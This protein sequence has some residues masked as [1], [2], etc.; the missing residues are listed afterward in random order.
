LGYSII[1]N[2]FFRLILVFCIIP[3]NNFLLSQSDKKDK[4]SKIKTSKKSKFYSYW[5]SYRRQLDG[6]NS[7][8]FFISVPYFEAKKNKNGKIKTV[9]KYND[10]DKKIDSWHLVWDRKGIRSEYSVKFHQNGLIT[11]LDSLLFSHKLS[12]IKTGWRAKVKS[13]R[14]GRPLR[15][16][17][18][19]ENGIRY[20]F[21]RFHYKQRSDSL[22]SMEIIQSSYFHSDSSLVGRHILFMENGEWLREIH[23]KNSKDEVEQIV[24]FDVSL[25]KEET[26][27]TTLDKDGRKIESRIIQLSYPDKYSYN[28]EWKPD[29]IMIVE[30][31]KIV[32]DTT[33]TYISPVLSSF[34][35]GLPLVQGS[36]LSSEPL[37]PSYGFFF[38]PRGNMI[39]NGQKYSLGMEVVSYNIPLQNDP[40][41][42]ISGIGAFAATQYELN[43]KIDWIP[44]NVEA[45]LRFGGG[46]LAS[47]YG[48]SFSGSFGYHFLPSRYYLGVYA[49]SIIAFDEV[50]EETV[51]SWGSLGLSLGANVGDINP[52]L[53]KPYQD[54]LDEPA[55]IFDLFKKMITKSNIVFT[56]GNPVYVDTVITEFYYKP[57][58]FNGL[59][60][61][62]P[63]S[64]N[65]G[66]L[67]FDFILGYL[68]YIFES[69]KINDQSYEGS[70]YFFGTNI[71][72]DNLLKFGGERFDKSYLLGIG[73]YHSGFGICT[74][75]ELDYHFDQIPIFINAYGRVYGLPNEEIFT[76]W[77]SVGLG[78]G[79][80]L[81]NL[82]L[83]L[84]SESGFKE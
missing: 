66:K 74:G 33:I 29:T 59:T 20:Y 45:S 79:I 70:A 11:R 17:I 9:T 24:K 22:L 3:Y 68:D 34:W 75:L 42:F 14:D 18:Y 73:S 62:T 60:I 27:K 81:D 52:D 12:E 56:Y 31:I 6:Q 47:G 71:V 65:L 21:Y 64:L 39:I 82:S 43:K 63:F 1:K 44:Q 10:K 46:M 57:D 16:D 37:Y 55:L 78:L 80:E 30:D 15:Y 48:F 50:G 40:D 76:G 8:D 83:L 41:T 53:L 25:E 2:Y 7:R 49:Q 23:Y 4:I 36:Q 26:V 54:K 72:L 38:A 51:T 69:K 58:Q 19:D 13:R 77:L 61:R 84:K 5:N 35:Y 32:E 67:K 28:F